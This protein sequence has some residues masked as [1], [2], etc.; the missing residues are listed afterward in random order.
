MKTCSRCNS[1]NSAT[2]KFCSECGVSFQT[3]V[4]SGMI[5]APSVQHSG[6]LNLDLEHCIQQARQRIRTLRETP[7]QP[8]SSAIAALISSLPTI[9]PEAELAT[10]AIIQALGQSKDPA[11]LK[12][13]LLASTSRAKNVRIAVATALGSIRHSL[14][15]YLL[16]PMLRDGSSRVR[17]SALQSLIAQRQPQ[18]SEVLIAA[19]LASSSMRSTALT[20]LKSLSASGRTAISAML[21]DIPLGG[22]PAATAVLQE[23][24]RACAGAGQAASG[25]SETS[26]ERTDRE[27]SFT[28]THGRDADHCFQDASN[29]HATIGQHASG[30][31]PNSTGAAVWQTPSDTNVSLDE[32]DAMPPVDTKRPASRSLPVDSRSSTPISPPVLARS[33]MSLDL[34]ALQSLP[35][36]V[37]RGSSV[38]NGERRIAELFDDADEVRAENAHLAEAGARSSDS[39]ADMTFFESIELKQNSQEMSQLKSPARASAAEAETRSGGHIQTSSS[40]MDLVSD[41]SAFL[42]GRPFSATRDTRS[43]EA[44]ARRFA[45]NGTGPEMDAGGGAVI[46]MPGTSQAGMHA[47]APWTTPVVT[48]HSYSSAQYPPTEPAQY[49]PVPLPP[50]HSASWPQ[51]PAVP[52]PTITDLSVSSPLIPAFSVPAF[53]PHAHTANHSAYGIDSAVHGMP[54]NGQ[55]GSATSGQSSI[56]TMAAQSP[57]LVISMSGDAPEEPGEEEQKEKMAAYERSLQRLR[58]ARESAFEKL[59]ETQEDISSNVPRLLSRRIAALLST[60]STD[61]EKLTAQLRQIGETASPAAL[62]ILSI[63]CQKPAKDLRLACARALGMIAHQRSAVLLLKLLSDK[64]GTVVEA[65]VASMISVNVDSVRGVILAAGLVTGSL[66]TV[67]SSGIEAASD[68][69]KPK[70]EQLLLSKLNL[71][72]PE[73]VAF[74]ISLLGRI[75]GATHYDLY[76]KLVRSGSAVERAAAVDALVRTGEK[77]AISSINEALLDPEPL[78]RSQA[79]QGIATIHSP[80][81]IELLGRLLSDPDL[82]VRRSAAQAAARIED[83]GLSDAIAAA[84]EREADAVTVESLLAALSQNEAKSAFAVLT[85]Y[86]EDKSS[87]FRDPAL[88]ALKKL[89]S[90]ESIPVFR[91]LLDD[92]HPSNRRQSVEQ[93]ALLKAEGVM[94]RFREMLKRD[95]DENVRGACARALGDLQDKS[96]LQLLEDALEDH[97]VVRLQAVI[98]LGK[99]NQSSVGP[100]LLTLLKDAQPEIRYQAVRA[101]GQLKLEGCDEAV[102]SLL[103]DKDE[104]VRRGAEQALQDLGMT[105]RQIRNKRFRRKFVFV[106]SKFAP[107]Y[108]AG[109]VPGGSKSLLTVIT[110]VLMTGGI[111]MLSNAGSFVWGAPK[112]YGGRVVSVAISSSNQRAFVLRSRDVLDVV[113]AT[114]GSLL[115]RTQLPPGVE[116]IIPESKG[117]LVIVIGSTIGRLDP[118]VSFSADAMKSLV[119]EQRPSATCLH[120][121]S[122]SLCVFENKAGTTTLRVFDATTLEEKQGFTIKALFK[123]RCIVSPDF[124]MALMLDVEGTLTLC[125]LASGEIFSA[126]VAR[127]TKQSSLGAILGVTFTNDM[128]YVCFCTSVGFIALRVDTLSLVKLVNNAGGFIAAQSLPDSSGLV[129]VTVG[130]QLFTFTNDFKTVGESTVEGFSDLLGFDNLGELMILADSEERDARVYSI[131]EKKSVTDILAEQ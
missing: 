61:I 122:N 42:N 31:T 95:T 121:T 21:R 107:S 1:A 53:N 120:G 97:Q 9:P 52:E 64:S 43:A 84:L 62:E 126:D 113:S 68:D 15:A 80:R 129:A 77:R 67:V 86:V 59:L 125:E 7:P 78:V 20:S 87:Q 14:A 11:V 27:L 22:H 47:A 116:Q 34:T 110:V 12:S 40:E 127:M 41:V 81:S 54:V 38:E 76:E 10:I 33:S 103:Q 16:L 75:T 71:P 94:P 57:R 101:M 123:G 119:L 60:P 100:V 93:L 92:S 112:L 3:A 72:D 124:K 105:V 50:M 35:E 55:T 111:W 58:E 56:A 63:F 46:E 102:E 104:M 98:A 6:S 30:E 99:L 69:E 18:T 29:R 91:R 65:A 13:F 5:G 118:D 90:P 37:A 114:E 8:A 79:A 25:D 109:A 49:P 96:S 128:K 70:W 48:P 131:K 26:H 23:L 74:S 32:I 117:G 36:E 44:G 39:F 28:A 85:R 88:K 89:K 2:A 66:R 73:L 4:N 19:C 17:R 82:S 45:Q 115:T 106:A 24:N 83:E 130:G 51:L 108:L